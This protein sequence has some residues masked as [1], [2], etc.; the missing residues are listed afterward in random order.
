MSFFLI[1]LLQNFDSITLDVDSLAPDARVKPEWASAPG[2]KGIE[3][4]WARSH[5]TLYAKV[6]E[7]FASLT[8][9]REC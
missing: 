3:K 6:R 9:S 5:L 1:R 2:R 7:F 8:A 4:F